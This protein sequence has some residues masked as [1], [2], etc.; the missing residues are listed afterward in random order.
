MVVAA[1]DTDDDATSAVVE[2]AGADAGAVA[3][4]DVVTAGAVAVVSALGSLDVTEGSSSAGGEPDI[5]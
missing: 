1:V 2:V 3:G 4:S 5:G